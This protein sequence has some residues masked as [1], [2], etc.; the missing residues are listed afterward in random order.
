[1]GS[2]NYI[3]LIKRIL[4]LPSLSFTMWPSSWQLWF[5]ESNPSIKTCLTA[6]A[7]TYCAIYELWC[8]KRCS[9]PIGEF[10]FN[11]YSPSSQNWQY[12]DFEFITFNNEPI[13]ISFLIHFSTKIAFLIIIIFIIVIYFFFTIC[14]KSFLMDFATLITNLESKMSHHVKFLRKMGFYGPKVTILTIFVPL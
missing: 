4:L 8:I 7:S 14:L 2:A 9:E 1:M 5:H 13:L 6:I 3:E 12:N 10:L 11:L